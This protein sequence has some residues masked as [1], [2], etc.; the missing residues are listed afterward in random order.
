MPFYLHMSYLHIINIDRVALEEHFN[1]A[2]NYPKWIFPYPVCWYQWYATL[3]NPKWQS[4][5]F[6]TFYVYITSWYELNS[7]M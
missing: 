7:S 3:D 2:Q 4:N 6:W 1:I 5:E